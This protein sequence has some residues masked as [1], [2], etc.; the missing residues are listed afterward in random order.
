[1]IFRPI[2]TIMTPGQI[3]YVE[4][5]FIRVDDTYVSQKMG[6]IDACPDCGRHAEAEFVL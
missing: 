2:I 6:G 5:N 3:T 1:M 4:D